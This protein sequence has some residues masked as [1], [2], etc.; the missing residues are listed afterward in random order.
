MKATAPSPAAPDSSLSATAASLAAAAGLATTAPS[1]VARPASLAVTALAPPIH[2]APNGAACSPASRRLTT[3]STLA[4]D[5]QKLTTASRFELA[6][7]WR[8]RFG[9]PPPKAI[10]R[11]L[12][13]RALAYALQVDALGGLSKPARRILMTIGSAPPQPLKRRPPVLPPGTRLVRDWHGHTH[14]VE[15]M[16]SGFLWN[17]S[18]HRSLSAIATARQ[19]SRPDLQPY[20]CR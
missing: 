5:L 14:V 19:S 9:Q 17:G 7:L 12:I 8:T 13:L 18:R 3:F 15:V 20:L 16:E 2:A 11:K 1:L 10:S 6:Q 4:E